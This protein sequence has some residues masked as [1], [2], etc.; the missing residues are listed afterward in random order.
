MKNGSRIWWVIAFGISLVLCGFLIHNVW[1]KWDQSPVIVSF[2]EK[3]T[4][5]YAIPFP[6][7]T[8]CPE[9]KTYVRL[10]NFTEMYHVVN[11]NKPPY[12]ASDEE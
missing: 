1:I 7:I 5:V 3:T 12:N 2:A 9:T 11:G 6:A 10:F 8:I 4:P